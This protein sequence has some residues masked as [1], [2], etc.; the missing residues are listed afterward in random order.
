VL[1]SAE[2]EDSQSAGNT[3]EAPVLPSRIVLDLL[4]QNAYEIAVTF[5]RTGN[6]DC[7][8]K[9]SG[10]GRFNA[11]RECALCA[12]SKQFRKRNSNGDD[13]ARQHP[14]GL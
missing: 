12:L 3:D 6:F 5:F 2:S 7:A 13:H 10:E 14:Y 4:E 9:C 1:L 8:C 11:N